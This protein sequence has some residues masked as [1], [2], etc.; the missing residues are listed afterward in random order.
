MK[1]LIQVLFCLM[2]V[3]DSRPFQGL[4]SVLCILAPPIKHWEDNERNE[5]SSLQGHY[6]STNATMSR[7]G[8]M[9]REA[10]LDSASMETNKHCK[11]ARWKVCRIKGSILSLLLITQS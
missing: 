6:V 2:A 11:S 9:L 5:P 4:G 8:R 7:S 1:S 3:P 10:L